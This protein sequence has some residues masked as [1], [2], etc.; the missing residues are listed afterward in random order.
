MVTSIP[1]DLSAL[2]N[3]NQTVSSSAVV[4]NPMTILAN[5]AKFTNEVLPPPV[6]Q[7][8]KA[9]NYNMTPAP[10]SIS[11]MKNRVISGGTLTRKN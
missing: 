2:K 6:V 3:T 8:S 11:A 9:G 1:S 7:Q 10:S 4:T 5:H